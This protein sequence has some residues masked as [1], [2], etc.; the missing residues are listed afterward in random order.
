MAAWNN[1][2]IV[3]KDGNDLAGGPKSFADDKELDAELAKYPGATV[4]AQKPQPKPKT[5]PKV[6]KPSVRSN[7]PPPQE[8]SKAEEP[9]KKKSRVNEALDR[10]SNWFKQGAINARNEWGGAKSNK[11]A[12]VNMADRML[13]FG[14]GYVGGNAATAAYD[15]VA[16]TGGKLDPEKQKILAGKDDAQRQELGKKGAEAYNRTVGANRV[17]DAGTTFGAQGYHKGDKF[18]DGGAVDIYNYDRNLI[19]RRY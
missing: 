13:R 15:A 9:E 11:G 16:R 12:L 1:V 18:G 10:T 8:E 6:S 4:T 7:P 5:A 14:A 2:Y 3:D 17:S 19:T